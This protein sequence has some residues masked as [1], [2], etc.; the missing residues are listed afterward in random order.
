VRYRTYLVVS[1]L[2]ATVN[3][4]LMIVFGD[5]LMKGQATVAIAALAGVVVVVTGIRIVRRRL[6]ARA[7]AALAAEAAAEGRAGDGV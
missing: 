6:A 1:W 4:S 7:E 3:I 2:V 5:A